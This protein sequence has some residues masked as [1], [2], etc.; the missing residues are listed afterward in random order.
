MWFSELNEVSL[1]VE[2]E[3]ISQVALLNV[4]GR[5]G[6]WQCIK[7]DCMSTN[8]LPTSCYYEN[9]HAYGPTGS[10][11]ISVCVSAGRTKLNYLFLLCLVRTFGGKVSKAFRK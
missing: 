1:R 2:T 10:M 11:H 6:V 8:I 9:D 4:C 7:V 3:N 5:Q